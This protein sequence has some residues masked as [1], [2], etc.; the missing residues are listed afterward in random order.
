[1]PQLAFFYNRKHSDKSSR[2][3]HYDQDSVWI[4]SH[5]FISL[6]DRTFFASR[7]PSTRHKKD[8]TKR[9]ARHRQALRLNP[10][11]RP[12]VTRC[13][14]AWSWLRP[15]GLRS[16]L[17]EMWGRDESVDY[18]LTEISCK[19]KCG[20][21]SRRDIKEDK[22]DTSKARKGNYVSSA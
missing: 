11:T 5:L 9:F 6:I 18:L 3:F 13:S 1:M 22:W 8:A 21:Y 15:L 2:I 10:Y 12:N 17:R 20:S 19:Y 16:G 14:V 7:R 4:N